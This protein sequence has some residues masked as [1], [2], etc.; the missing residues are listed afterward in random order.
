MGGINLQAIEGIRQVLGDQE[1]IQKLA[2][3]A[4][5]EQQVIIDELNLLLEVKEAQAAGDVD[6][7]KEA[8][9]ELIEFQKSYGL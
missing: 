9:R 2:N 4:H 3:G 5:V 7:S 8:M 1:K 6:R